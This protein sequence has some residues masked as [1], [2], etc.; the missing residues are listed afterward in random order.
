MAKIRR[1]GQLSEATGQHIGT[2]TV[3]WI[4][5]GDIPELE[6]YVI[7]VYDELHNN[8]ENPVILFEGAQGFGL[9]IDWG[10]YPYVTSSHCTVEWSHG[11]FPNLLERF[12][13]LKGYETYVGAKGFEP[14]RRR[15]S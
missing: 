3:A 9:D 1:L 7:D 6:R 14:K 12:T 8:S 15:F 2:N 13:G 10:D 4:R 11:V 5:A